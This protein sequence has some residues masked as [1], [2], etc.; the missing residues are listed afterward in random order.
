MTA[1]QTNEKYL[2][3]AQDGTNNI[4]RATISYILAMSSSKTC[5]TVLFVSA[6]AA[7]LCIKG[8]VEGLVSEGLE[9]LAD[10]QAAF[11]QN[12]G[13]IWLC[14]A[15]AVAKGITAADLIEGVEIA[16]APDSMAFLA[17]GAKLL[18]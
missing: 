7:A 9:S 17:S 15:C 11:L 18:A 8:G 16:G 2:I 4:E 6:E 3:N 1:T 13:K 5:E 14:R 12:G 10:L